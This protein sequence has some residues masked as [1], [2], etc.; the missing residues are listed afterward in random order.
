M[1]R[2]YGKVA[3]RFWTD[4]RVLQLDGNAKLTLVYLLAGSQSN[5]V[6]CFRC[7]G[8]HLAADGVCTADEGELAL[9]RLADVGLVQRDPTAGLVWLPRW[10]RYNPI[11]NPNT[12]KG[13]VA[14]LLALPASPLLAAVIDSV[15]PFENFLPVDF[16]RRIAHLIPAGLG[17]TLGNTFGNTLGN[18]SCTPSPAQPNP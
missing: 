3:T 10:M 1:S 7:T 17:N 15:R 5:C 14:E 12:G 16:D 18:V 13:A 9:A 8:H 11:T 4:A 2:E 6:G